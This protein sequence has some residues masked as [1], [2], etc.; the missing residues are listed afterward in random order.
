MVAPKRLHKNA[1]V[2]RCPATTSDGE[3]QRIKTKLQQEPLKKESTAMKK[4][5]LT[6]IAL[7]GITAFAQPVVAAD[8][9]QTFNGAYCDNY[10]G[11]QATAVNHQYNGIYNTT[12][13]GVYV[14][15][16]LVVDEVTNVTGTNWVRLHYTGN[17]TI[18]CYLY[19]M[20][21]NGTIRQTQTGSRVGTGWFSIPNINTD[22]Y[23]GTY[24]MHC[25]LPGGGT[26]NTVH[27]SE[28]P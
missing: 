22:D 26:L 18:T 27:M 6:S 9:A 13:A 23:W 17:N 8:N 14:Q 16:P 3:H 25:Y 24:S 11:S 2:R 28:K 1:H 7:V 5:V 12:A 19:S 21:G 4:L 20:N 15:C 10:Y